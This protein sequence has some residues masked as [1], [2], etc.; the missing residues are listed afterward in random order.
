MI[1]RQDSPAL[2]SFFLSPLPHLLSS[3][4]FTSFSSLPLSL[5]IFTETSFLLSLSLSLFHLYSPLLSSS[6]SP[7]AREGL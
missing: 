7:N 3:L 5:S 1:D 4:S 2:L 6:L